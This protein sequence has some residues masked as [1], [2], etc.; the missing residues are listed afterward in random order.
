MLADAQAVR[1]RHKHARVAHCLQLNR[2]HDHKVMAEYGKALILDSIRFFNPSSEAHTFQ[3]KV[4]KFKILVVLQTHNSFSNYS[5]SLSYSMEALVGCL[6]RDCVQGV[7]TL[8]GA[9]RC[10]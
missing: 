4:R 9:D 1:E 5:D 10:T 7:N 6:P 2:M 8:H 3:L